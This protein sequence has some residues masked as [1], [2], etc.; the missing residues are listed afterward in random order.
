MRGPC[1]DALNASPGARAYYDA[2][3]AR[4]APTLLRATPAASSTAT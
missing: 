2:L 1:V 3:R 4:G